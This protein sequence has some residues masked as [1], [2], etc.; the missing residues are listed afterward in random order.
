MTKLWGEK[1]LHPFTRF[2][3]VNDTCA[4]TSIGYRELVGSSLE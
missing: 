2:R 4:Y 1:E 3:V